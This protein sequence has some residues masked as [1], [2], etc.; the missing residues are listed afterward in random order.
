MRDLIVSRQHLRSFPAGQELT[1]DII[2]E[3]NDFLV[4]CI[5]GRTV[6]ARDMIFILMEFS[7]TTE[8]PSTV[9]YGLS[10]QE[11]QQYLTIMTSIRSKD[12]IP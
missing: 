5:K 2:E 10:L 11:L 4:Y 6:K 8:A 1:P 9:E 3:A 12:E 7:E